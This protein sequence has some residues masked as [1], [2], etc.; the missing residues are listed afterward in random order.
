VFSGK[1]EKN[2]YFSEFTSYYP[3]PNLYD[4]TT[5]NGAVVRQKQAYI[6]W[7]LKL[8]YDFNVRNASLAA[9]TLF[10]WGIEY[11]L[12]YIQVGLQWYPLRKMR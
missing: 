6:S 12:P 3:Y 11:R 4:S 2:G 9:F 7:R 5:Y 8:A 10:N 1:E